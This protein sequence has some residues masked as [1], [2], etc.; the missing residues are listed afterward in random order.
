MQRPTQLGTHGQPHLRHWLKL[1]RKQFME[2]KGEKKR[3]IIRL[4]AGYL[5]TSMW[6]EHLIEKRKK[7]QMGG[8]GKAN[9]LC[10]WPSNIWLCQK[11]GKNI[12]FN[13][14]CYLYSFHLACHVPWIMLLSIKPSVSSSLTSFAPLCCW[15]GHSP[16]GWVTPVL[17]SCPL[18]VLLFENHL[19]NE[20]ILSPLP[21]LCEK[22]Q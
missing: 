18:L 8:D 15:W 6:T 12:I 7:L 22:S 16:G 21:L 1:Y 11:M 2:F 10:S 14:L 13:E 20:C 17:P 3:K 19:Y 4:Q 5:W 9:V